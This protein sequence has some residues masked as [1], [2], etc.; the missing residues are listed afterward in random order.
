MALNHECICSATNGGATQ[1]TT[2]YNGR[3]SR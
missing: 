2:G 1:R 3:C